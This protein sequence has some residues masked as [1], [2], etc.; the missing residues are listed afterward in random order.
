MSQLRL[1]LVD[2]E[3][4]IRLGLCR[5]LS[6]LA[7]VAVV[8]EC[9][10][11]GEAIDFLL[12]QSADI[13]L[14]DV[15]MPDCSG[16]DVVREVGPARM[17]LV[18]FV[19]AYDEYAVK[20]FELNAVDYLLKPFDE[21]RLVASIERARARLTQP[22]QDLSQTRLQAL[23]NT[24]A[25]AWPERLVARTGER[26]EFI[27]VDTIDWIESANNYVQLHCGTKSHLLGQTL[28]ATQQRLDPRK[29]ARVHRGRIVNISRIIAV[30]A[31]LNGTY[32][33]Q[34]RNGIEITTG[35]Q[36]KEAVQK[37]LRT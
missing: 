10:S 7:D 31:I 26:Y 37:L 13:V 33:L 8:G 29:F 28:N 22:R 19:T 25:H 20:A 3:P 2:D 12:S 36:Y 4:L 27:P 11:G 17:P 23:L 34:L 15:Q 24:E 18:I 16:L 1:F 35:R 6:K 30:H 21:Q 32:Q 9:G 5:A 14:L